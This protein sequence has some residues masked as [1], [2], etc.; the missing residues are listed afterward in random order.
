M[1][2]PC[3]GS[4]SVL[5]LHAKQVESVKKKHS[6]ELRESFIPAQCPKFHIF[7]IKAVTVRI[8]LAR[9]CAYS[10][11]SQHDQPQAVRYH[12]F[13]SHATRHRCQDPVSLPTPGTGL[14]HKSRCNGIFSGP[15]SKTNACEEES[16]E[17]VAR[18]YIEISSAHEDSGKIVE[19]MIDFITT[20]S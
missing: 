19:V 17:G 16:Q 5:V 20:S 14:R 13:D 8:I 10:S 9:K 3:H 12:T 7:M 18:V 15:T 1:P 11:T 6:G 4:H 2:Q